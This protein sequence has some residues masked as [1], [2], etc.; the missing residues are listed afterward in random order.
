MKKLQ[1]KTEIGGSRLF[2]VIDF[3][4]NRKDIQDFLLVI[5]S[6]LGPILHRFWDTATYWLKITNFL[7]TRLI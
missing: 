7:Y 6:N 5:Y 4:V 3:D 1:K 2:T